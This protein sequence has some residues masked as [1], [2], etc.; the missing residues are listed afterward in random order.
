[1]DNWKELSGGRKIKQL[2][3][4]SIV[5]PETSINRVPLD[6]PVCKMLMS[7]FEDSIT[8]QEKKCCSYCDLIWAQP[9]K[10]KWE[11]GWRPNIDEV[12]KHLNERNSMPSFIYEVK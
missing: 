12:N 2:K 4:Y 9:N 6:C 11:Q 7:T 8:Y 1:M 10:Q 5:I 3:N